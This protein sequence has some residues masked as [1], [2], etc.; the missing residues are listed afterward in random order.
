MAK[1]LK[2]TMLIELAIFLLAI[3]FAQS[4]FA[5]GEVVGVIEDTWKAAA[6]QN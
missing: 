2:R 5:A 4:V 6:S 3:I 1:D